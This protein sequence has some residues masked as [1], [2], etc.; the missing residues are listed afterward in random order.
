MSVKR[1]SQRLY[2]EQDSNKGRARTRRKIR[3]EKGILTA[4]VQ[5][6]NGMVP[7]TETLCFETILSEE[8]AWPWQLPGNGRD[9]SCLIV[10]ANV[11]HFLWIILDLFSLFI[12][13]N[14][15]LFINASQTLSTSGR[16][17]EFLTVSWRNGDYR[18]KKRSFC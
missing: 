11:A 17:G 18:K 8:T 13:M 12:H 10:P 4:A 5:Q 15:S 9:N 2:K 3:E 16:R 7:S 6:Y 1:R 14:E